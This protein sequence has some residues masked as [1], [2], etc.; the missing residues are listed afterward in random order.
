MATKLTWL[1]LLAL[2]AGAISISAAEPL[3]AA[4]SVHLHFA[5][6][7]GDLFYN[8]LTVE[9]TTDG[10]YFMACGWN[11]G[12]FGMQQLGSSTNKVVIFS[13]WD[14]TQGDDANKVPLEQRVEILHEG[15]S[16]KIRRFG[17]E[18][19]G[20]QC[21][22]PY[23]WETNETCRFAVR[24]TVDGDK[25]SYAGWFFDNRT[26]AWQHLVTFRTRTGG[27]PLRGYYS[28]IED[29]RR[30]GKSATEVRR[31]SF[32]NG[33]V[34]DLKGEWTSLRRATFTASSS[35]WEAKENI[36]AGIS[37]GR[38]F[39]ATGGNTARLR[40]LGKAIELRA[41]VPG[42]IPELPEELKR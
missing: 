27:Q 33:W 6:P 35:E 11:T 29:F 24:A 22:W 40:E 4:R 3:R 21:L 28:F 15:V 30:D 8:E 14:P 10:S 7:S 36:D 9:Q 39:L 20:G 42:K 2:G 5:A 26:Q 16:A 1:W 38:F 17:G 37:A 19:T 31:A 13:V 23:L 12:Y 18:G 32:G 34:R 41:D 25:T